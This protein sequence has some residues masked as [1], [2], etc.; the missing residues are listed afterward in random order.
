ML[1]VSSLLLFSFVSLLLL[2]LLLL[3]LRMRRT[4]SASTSFPPSYSL[5]S[6][7]LKNRKNR[8]FCAIVTMRVD[9]TVNRSFGST[10]CDL[11]V[12]TTM[13]HLQQRF[14]LLFTQKIS[15]RSPNNKADSASGHPNPILLLSVIFM[16]SLSGGKNCVA[17]SRN[18]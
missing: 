3:L 4:M 7:F 13:V 5:S 17:A 18:T 11:S 15:P 1:F 9:T 16:S 8:V 6:L 14:V 12:G 2:L 10:P